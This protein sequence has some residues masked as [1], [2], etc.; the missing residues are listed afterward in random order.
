MMEEIK[1]LVEAFGGL[2]ET[3]MT[4]LFYFGVYKLTLYLSTT[5]ATVY[6]SK[7][8]ITRLFDHLDSRKEVTKVAKKGE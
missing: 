7:M 1:I 6:V 4:A 5:G 3:A 8:V 2:S